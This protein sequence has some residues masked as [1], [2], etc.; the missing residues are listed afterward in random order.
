MKY[1][2]SLDELVRGH[3]IVIDRKKASS[4]PRYPSVIYPIDYGFLENTTT[5][6]DGGI[7]IFVGSLASN[8]IQG[9]ICTI[10]RYKNDAEI[11]IMY[12]CSNEDIDAALKFLNEG[13]MSAIYVARSE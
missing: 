3:K 2:D 11:K 9:V 5:V 13:P 12:N 10:D 4:H 1:W 8:C 7:D 6:D